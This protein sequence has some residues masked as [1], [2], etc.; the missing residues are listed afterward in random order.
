[1]VRKINNLDA[2]G[3][4]LRVTAKEWAT[5]YWGVRCPDF[6]KDCFCCKA[7]AAVDA[8]FHGLEDEDEQ[9]VMVFT[10]LIRQLKNE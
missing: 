7:W 6:E 4:L 5:A 9:D 3:K 8:L 2:R 10:D 1:M